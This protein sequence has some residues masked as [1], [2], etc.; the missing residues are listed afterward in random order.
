MCFVSRRIVMISRHYPP[1]PG[2]AQ[3]LA[4]KFADFMRQHHA[5]V[6]LDV[7]TLMPAHVSEQM[8][9]IEEHGN[10]R[11]FRR[12][13]ALHPFFSRVLMRPNATLGHY[14]A[15]VYF[16]MLLGT[17]AFWHV[18]RC[19]RDVV[20]VYG[21]GGI[22]A[23]F[24][25]LIAGKCFRRRVV[26][27]YEIPFSFSGVLVACKPFVRWVNR[28]IDC[29][30]CYSTATAQSL[31]RIGVPLSRMQVIRN[32]IDTEAFRPGDRQAARETLRLPDRFTLLFVGRFH[33]S[34]G[35]LHVAGIVPDFPQIH[36]VFVGGTGDGEEVV[37]RLA[38]THPNVTVFGPQPQASLPIFYQA[39]DAFGWAY[40]E[41]DTFGM[42]A[43]ESLSCGVPV[44][45]PR[46]NITTS[47]PI[48]LGADLERAVRDG[49]GIIFEPDEASYQRA[50]EAAVNQ[51]YGLRK[52]ADGCR[53]YVEAEC[54][55]ENPERIFR[56]ILGKRVMTK[57]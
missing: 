25:A 17:R 36:F 37:Q 1:D 33:S 6:K 54:G 56:E 11:V 14:V 10:V 47:P 40:A 7:V 22:I 23:A 32:W 57:Q 31:A 8:P 46:V 26:V 49:L 13:G 44:L 34:R 50:V 39:A 55:P 41:D 9:L 5:E 43:Y 20:A 48:P 12:T 3:V 15:F 29:I 45:V 42:T 18:W 16:A 53:A 38:A 4:E 51:G 24:V 52:R 30:I 2:G 28:R 19:R 27:H 35:V 21:F